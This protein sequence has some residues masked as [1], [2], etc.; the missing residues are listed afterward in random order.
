MLASENLTPSDLLARELA[1]IGGDSGEIDADGCDAKKNVP[2]KRSRSSAQLTTVRTNCKGV[3]MLRIGA[4]YWDH[5]GF[6][7]R[8]EP[9]VA[10]SAQGG[11]DDGGAIE[12]RKE[13]GDAEDAATLSKAV[14]AVVTGGG[15]HGREERD[16][17]VD[18]LEVVRS[19]FASVAA[20]GDACSRHLVRLVPLQRTCFAGPDEIAEALQPMLERAFPKEA[21]S[22]CTFMV[23]L[24]RRNNN[25]FDKDAM[26]SR[27]VNMVN[28]G[29]AEGSKHVVNLTA[30]QK[31][32]VVEINQAL[33][34]VTVLD[35]AHCS[36][37]EDTGAGVDG[38]SSSS[39]SRTSRDAVDH[40]KTHDFNLRRMQ[41]S[42]RATAATA[43]ATIAVS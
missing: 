26:V 21:S 31:V 20:T 36:F 25:A 11:G 40:V 19:L 41:D 7:P 30:P 42:A 2:K 34:G 15:G 37:Q 39:S 10:A 8:P 4:P 14:A 29:R 6:P 27:I 13:G 35:D 32:I 28:E 23:Q 12:K 22:C 18:P 17:V 1:E 24:K 38:S 16:G 43:D 5:E 33:C 3:V 9:A